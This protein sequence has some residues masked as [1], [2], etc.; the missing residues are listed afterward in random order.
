M[1][2][3]ELI[4]RTAIKAS[5]MSS[6]K[7]KEF[8]VDVERII[9]AYISVVAEALADGQKICIKDFMVIEPVTQPERRGRNPKTG[10]VDTFPA[11]KRVHCRIAPKIK[12]QI[13]KKEQGK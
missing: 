12:R 2:K 11:V 9:D 10:E 8:C 6:W 4:K 3:K 7:K 13:N 1:T 5:E